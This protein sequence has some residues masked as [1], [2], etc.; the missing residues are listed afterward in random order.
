MDGLLHDSLLNLPNY[1]LAFLLEAL[2][3]NPAP[4]FIVYGPPACGKGE[5]CKR[6]AAH[7]G[8][9]HI[10]TG[11]LLREEIAK[12]SEL[13]LSAKQFMDSGALVP[14]TVITSL[15]K[16]RLSQPDTKSKGWVLDGFPRTRAQAISL[17]IEGVIPMRFIS[18]DV[19]D[20]VCQERVAGRVVDPST[21]ISYNS[22]TNPP[23]AGVKT[24]V[25]TDDGVDDHKRRLAIH[26]RNEPE[27]HSCYPGA[28]R[29]SGERTPDEIFVDIQAAVDAKLV[30]VCLLYT[31]PS[32][33]DS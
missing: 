25:R 6:I 24:E 19:S 9:V 7:T 18:I 14:D 28:L 17:Q 26:R 5:Q 33:R 3:T 20:A 2:A 31:S 32:P 29:V 11:D 21:G 1:P 30:T 15:L 23:P 22:T 8:A 4:K 13:G 27:V 10:S 12:G 16:N